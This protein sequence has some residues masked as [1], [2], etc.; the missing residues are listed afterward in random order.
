MTTKKFP[1]TKHFNAF[2]RYFIDFLCS[3]FASMPI[4]ATK[5]YSLVMKMRYKVKT[6]YDARGIRKWQMY[7]MKESKQKNKWRM[8]EIIRITTTM[9]RHLYQFSMVLM[10]FVCEWKPPVSRMFHF[11]LEFKFKMD[12]VLQFSNSC[13]VT[14]RM[15][16]LFSYKIDAIDWGRLSQS[17]RK[18]ERE[19][20]R[21][22]VP[23]HIKSN[24][25]VEIL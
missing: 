3:E 20:E 4:A 18:M 13:W 5:L 21:E 1:I 10:H 25:N 8:S 9:K 11:K 22:H 14:F 17:V 12:F 6:T 15:A 24:E 16:C 23:F 19:R 7:R 2:S